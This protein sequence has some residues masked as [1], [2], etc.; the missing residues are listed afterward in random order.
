MPM[1]SSS[2][3]C[4]SVEKNVAHSATFTLSLSMAARP[5]SGLFRKGDCGRNLS[6]IMSFLAHLPGSKV[7]SD[8]KTLLKSVSEVM[9]FA[10]PI[11]LSLFHFASFH[12]CSSVP[13]RWFWN[14]LAKDVGF[15]VA[16]S[17]TELQNDLRSLIMGPG[18]R[19][20]SIVFIAS[21]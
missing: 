7:P 9:V 11:I 15:L 8:C 5:F 12:I 21:C 2:S 6:S 20:L 14:L 1:R 4:G 16:Q 3:A 10:L 13:L 17:H 19:L 18:F